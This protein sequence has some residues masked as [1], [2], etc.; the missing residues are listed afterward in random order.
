MTTPTQ[1]A[2]RHRAEA[3]QLADGDVVGVVLRQHADIL[4]AIEQVTSGTG[5]ARADDWDRLSRL[6]RAHETAEQEVI[7]PLVQRSDDPQEAQARNAEEQEADQEVARLSSMG[8]DSPDFRPAFDEFAGTV[9]DHAEAE[10]QHELSMLR[11]LPWARRVE[12]G[13]EFLAAFQA[14]G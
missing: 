7:R 1:E 14:A 8:A 13:A 3:D 11:E 4:D 10:E 9:H 2:S 5:A 6:L 12:L